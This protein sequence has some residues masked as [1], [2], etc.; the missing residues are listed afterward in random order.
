M[1]IGHESS[2]HSSSSSRCCQVLHIFISSTC[3]EGVYNPP[4]KNK[5]SE[6]QCCKRFCWPDRARTFSSPLFSFCPFLGAI[7]I[8]SF[9]LN[10]GQASFP[11]L[12][13][14]SWV[15]TRGSFMLLVM[16]TDCSFFERDCTGNSER[17]QQWRKFGRTGT[18]ATAPK[19]ER[20]IFIK[21]EG[22]LS[23]IGWG[24][25]KVSHLAAE[26]E[27]YRLQDFFSLFVWDDLCLGRPVMF[28]ERSGERKKRERKHFPYWHGPS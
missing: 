27:T 19:T 14:H 15:C 20:P 2:I 4:I 25:T 10:L 26:A 13:S 5:V 21:S 6:N 18:N 11:L 17:E 22:E 24:V 7:L 12:L 3:L 16:K 8:A 28:I 9:N 1:G 23:L